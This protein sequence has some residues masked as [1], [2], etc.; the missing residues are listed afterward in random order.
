[1]QAVCDLSLP[2][3]MS[4]IVNI[5]IQQGGVDNAAP[6]VIR[7]S[8]LDKLSIF[9]EE[10]DLKYIEENYTLIN[11]DNLSNDELNKYLK[12]YP[13]LDEEPLYE[14]NTKDKDSISR[15][16]SILAKPELI[17]YGIETGSSDT[18]M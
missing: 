6:T 11:K 13:I 4:D 10:D 2:D 5:G 14:L 18:N 17:V 7:K 16:S 3:Y 1:I 12:K 8:E 9:I 15:L